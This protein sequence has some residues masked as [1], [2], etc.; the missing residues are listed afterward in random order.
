MARWLRLAYGIAAVSG[1][2]ALGVAPVAAAEEE[3]QIKCERCSCNLNTGTCDCT[4]CTITGCKVN[5]Q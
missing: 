2:L 5:P 4:N 3:C 1:I